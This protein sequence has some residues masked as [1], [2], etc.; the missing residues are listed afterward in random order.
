MTC[1]FYNQWSGVFTR[2]NNWYDIDLIQ[3]GGEYDQTFGNIE[4]TF[5]LIG[6]GI[7]LSFRVNEPNERGKDIIKAAKEYQD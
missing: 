6:F 3:I 7:F 1:H 2:S 5:K 4:F